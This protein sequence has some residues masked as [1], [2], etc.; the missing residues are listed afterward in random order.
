M[1]VSFTNGTG[2]AFNIKGRILAIPYFVPITD[3]VFNINRAGVLL[4]TESPQYFCTDAASLEELLPMLHLELAETPIVWQKDSVRFSIKE[5]AVTASAY[6]F[7]SGADLT[8]FLETPYSGEVFSNTD[9]SVWLAPALQIKLPI[10]VDV[11]GETVYRPFC[12]VPQADL[13]RFNKYRAMLRA[14]RTALSA[15]P[16][17]SAFFG[18][19][20]HNSV[21]ITHEAISSNVVADSFNILVYDGPILVKTYAGALNI[22]AIVGGLLPNGAY[23]AKCFFKNGTIKGAET[24]L[25]VF[26][27][28]YESAPTI[29]ATPSNARFGEVSIELASVPEWAGGI[30]MEIFNAGFQYGPTHIGADA[31]LILPPGSYTAKGYTALVE[32]DAPYYIAQCETAFEISAHPPVDLAYTPN[33]DGTA[34]LSW[35]S[36]YADSTGVLYN[37]Y[38][39]GHPYLNTQ[40]LSTI[41]AEGVYEIDAIYDMGGVLYYSPIV[42]F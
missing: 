12:Y 21:T 23:E 42:Q 29:T 4:S 36:F 11:Y 24:E 30:F 40:N 22:P 9:Y 8:P 7:E 32:S 38:L 28:Q 33:G 25:L 3:G 35:A 39:G 1:I 37:V 10:G 20:T 27:S 31:V 15:P 13:E 34:T 18:G 26:T 17:P 5:D 14:E 16:A 2:C 19:F 6:G 41:V